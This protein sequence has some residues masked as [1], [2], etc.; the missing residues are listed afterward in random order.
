[1]QELKINSYNTIWSAAHK[2][3][4][5]SQRKDKYDDDVKILRAFKPFLHKSKIALKKDK[6]IKY[7]SKPSKSPK[8]GLFG[9][10]YFY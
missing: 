9:L 6:L 2:I 3:K 7:F 1:M 4:A 8:I 10:N 5:V